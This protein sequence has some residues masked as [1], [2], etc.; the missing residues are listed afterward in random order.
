LK[1]LQFQHAFLGSVADAGDTAGL[2]RNSLH[3]RIERFPWRV[4]SLDAND[5]KEGT[6]PL[7]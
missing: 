5:V 1:K 3:S 7:V 4:L 6:R 2:Y